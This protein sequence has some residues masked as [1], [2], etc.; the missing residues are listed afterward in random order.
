M[1]F[2]DRYSGDA[3]N[4]EEIGYFIGDG[5]F[6]IDKKFRS[7]ENRNH[8]LMGA[9]LLTAINQV[10]LPEQHRFCSLRVNDKENDQWFNLIE[11]T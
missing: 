5:E 6:R 10:Q 9:A 1:T 4:F 8:D 3:K 11:R 7:K 2:T